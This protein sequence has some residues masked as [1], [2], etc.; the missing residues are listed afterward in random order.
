MLEFGKGLFNKITGKGNDTSLSTQVDTG[1]A[2]GIKIKSKAAEGQKYF[3]MDEKNPKYA[4]VKKVLEEKL[5]THKGDPIILSLVIGLSLYDNGGIGIRH[6]NEDGLTFLT[7]EEVQNVADPQHDL[8]IGTGVLIRLSEKNVMATVAEIDPFSMVDL[9]KD[10]T[11]VEQVD[12]AKLATREGIN[13]KLTNKNTPALQADKTPIVEVEEV[14]HSGEQV[15]VRVGIYELVFKNIA[16]NPIKVHDK[17]AIHMKDPELGIRNPGNIDGI[18][19]V[20]V[21]I[22]RRDE[23]PAV[24]NQPQLL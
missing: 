22:V 16:A 18:Y 10:L 12:V 4:E 3:V 6:M 24:P 14:S 1:L 23:K 8:A 9:S 5:K 7:K 17:L 13:V 11:G 2:S 21:T 15:R 19:T 20:G